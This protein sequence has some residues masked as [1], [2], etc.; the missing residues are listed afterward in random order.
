MTE[1]IFEN[2]LGEKIHTISFM[3]D[4]KNEID[5]NTYIINTPRIKFLDKRIKTIIISTESDKTIKQFYLIFNKKLEVSTYEKMKKVYGDSYKVFLNT[6]IDSISSHSE[7]VQN[8]FQE[9]ITQESSILKQGNLYDLNI[10]NI[11]WNKSSF[12][13]ILLN[14]SYEDRTEIYFKKIK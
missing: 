14:N 6:K 8:D 11:I 1:N 4:L 13:M 2:K 10:N 7:R 12:L 5:S 9:E 3:G